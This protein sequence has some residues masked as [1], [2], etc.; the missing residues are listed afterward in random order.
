MKRSNERGSNLEI[1]AD[2]MAVTLF[3]FIIMTIVMEPTDNNYDASAQQSEVKTLQD[4]ELAKSESGV[5]DL[6]D[7]L[8]IE[9]YLY[10]HTFEIV[11]EESKVKLNTLEEVERYI[12]R[13]TPNNGGQ[14]ILYADRDIS[15][16]EVV[17][18][19]DVIKRHIPQAEIN[20][21]VATKN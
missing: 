3:I 16:Q 4:M 20:I 2:I 13:I 12:R 1:G 11:Q 7:L 14:F 21:G 10:H 9:V 19:I 17:S 5:G 15:F 18:T 6:E 8:R